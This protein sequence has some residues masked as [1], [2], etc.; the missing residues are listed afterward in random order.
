MVERADWDGLADGLYEALLRLVPRVASL[1][2]ELAGDVANVRVAGFAG[3]H[4]FTAGEVH[5]LLTVSGSALAA[6]ATEPL[7]SIP[8]DRQARFLELHDRL[9]PGTYYTGAQLLEMAAE[10]VATVLGRVADGDL[11]GYA[12]GRIDEGGGGYLDFV[13]VDP[14]CRRRGHG[15]A[16]VRAMCGALRELQPIPRL[17]LTVG[18][19]NAAALELYRELGFERTSSMVGYRRPPGAPA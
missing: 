4:G 14:G 16:L 15:R 1:D 3:R 10:G 11:V 13:G 19:A 2:Q 12:A 8:P 7:P 5:H 18:G 17:R 6:L 9:F